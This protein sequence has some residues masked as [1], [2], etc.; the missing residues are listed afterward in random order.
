MGFE[1]EIFEWVSDGYCGSS[2]FYGNRRPQLQRGAR[3]LCVSDLLL[4]GRATIEEARTL[5]HWLNIKQGFDK[6]GV[7]G[8]SMGIFSV[9][10]HDLESSFY[11]LLIMLL[12]VVDI[13]R[14]SFVLA[15]SIGGLKAHSYGQHKSKGSIFERAHKACNKSLSLSKFAT[16]FL[17]TYV[18]WL[19]PKVMEHNFALP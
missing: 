18:Q 10:C 8:L 5:L 17:T 13:V 4:L 1:R 14:G 16:N 9:T 3:L 15:K 19:W 12:L 11:F 6:L 7:C 2:P